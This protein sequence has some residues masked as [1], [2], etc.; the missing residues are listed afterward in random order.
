MPIWSSGEA[1]RK[2]TIMT[3]WLFALLLWL[4]SLTAG[5]LGA[6]TG[7]GGGVILIPLLTLVF[8]VDFRYAVGAGLISIMAVSAGSAAAY[9]RRG[10]VNLRIGMGLELL[11]AVGALLGAYIAPFIATSQLA[12]VFGTVLLVTVYLTSRGHNEGNSHHG[13]RKPSWID[14][15][16]LSSNYQEDGCEI[17]YH[18]QRPVLSGTVMLGAGVISGLLGIGAG[19]F[20]VL[21]MDHIMRLPFKV[22]TTTSNFM[23][24]VTA[25][26]SAGIYLGRGY[27]DPGIALPVFLGTLPGALLGSRVLARADVKPLRVVFAVLVTVVAVRMIWGGLAGG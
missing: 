15:L 12:V 27:I 3:L 20:K 7:L 24:G 19:A 13:G 11:T 21:S 16:C 1:S 25:A 17:P 6:M 4:G 8:R 22:S 5:F 10:L 14:R 23:M 18:P 2:L 26:A 9:L